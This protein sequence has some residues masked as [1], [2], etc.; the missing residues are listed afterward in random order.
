MPPKN[1]FT[2][3]EIIQAGVNVVR[4]GGIDSLTA[5]STALELKSSTKVIFGAFDSMDSLAYEVKKRAYELYLSHQ[6]DVTESGRYPVY[7]AS[8]MAYISFAREEKELFKLLFM[9]ENGRSEDKDDEF[10]HFTGVVRDGLNLSQSKANL[11]HTEMWIFVHGIATMLATNFCA[12]SEEQVS[13]MLNDVFMGIQ[14][15]FC[16]T[17]KAIERKG[18][19]G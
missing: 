2:K 19:N 14:E 13:T 17:N 9:C 10:E 7:K 8:G 15:R 12:W 6:S 18:T 1:K 4:K 16:G 5:R 3:D 11:F